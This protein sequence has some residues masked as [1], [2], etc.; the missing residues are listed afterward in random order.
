MTATALVKSSSLK[1]RQEIIDLA[2][3]FQKL[4]KDAQSKLVRLSNL[5]HKVQKDQL[6]REWINPKTK[7]AFTSFENWIKVDV[8]Q[9]KS[10]VYRFIGVKEHLNL[11]DKTLEL[12]GPSRCFELVKVA[13]EKPKMLQK[14]VKAIEA[15]PEIPVYTVQQMATNV[16][17]G[18]NFDSGNYDR[19]DFAVRVEDVHEIHQAFAVMQSMEPVK[20]PDTPTGRGMHLLNLCQDFLSRP[21]ERQV[22]KRLE[23]AGAFKNG[24]TNFIFEDD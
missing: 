9:S 19:L 21:K 4:Q 20:F 13:K 12:I 16:L 23:D 22:L 17:A 6:F 5:V 10:S 15:N 8:R 14:I 2:D 1:I 18:S 24:N 11:P 3:E 7:K